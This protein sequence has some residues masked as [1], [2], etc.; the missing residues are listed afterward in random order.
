MTFPS[1]LFSVDKCRFVLLA[2]KVF[3]VSELQKTTSQANNDNNCW[4]YGRSFS[5]GYYICGASEL[6]NYFI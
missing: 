2:L 5:S 4:Y 1:V 3:V 6:S